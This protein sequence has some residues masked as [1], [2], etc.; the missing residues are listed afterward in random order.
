MFAVNHLYYLA[1][2]Y[3][4]AP[5]SF[6]NIYRKYKP[7]ALLTGLNHE[8]KQFIDRSVHSDTRPAT[9]PHGSVGKDTKRMK[10]PTGKVSK[11]SCD[12][13]QLTRSNAVGS[14]CNSSIRT[15]SLKYSRHHAV[16]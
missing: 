7:L 5:P 4:H 11:Q 12:I 10:L 16:V 9:N 3:N 8:H 2:S 14:E 15:D 1:L 13:L 6:T